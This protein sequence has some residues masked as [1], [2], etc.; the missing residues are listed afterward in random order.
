MTLFTMHLFGPVTCIEIKLQM[1]LSSYQLY[2]LEMVNILAFLYLEFKFYK[3]FNIKHPL[4]FFIQLKLI[5]FDNNVI[6]CKAF[7]AVKQMA[8]FI[9]KFH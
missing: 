2:S 1:D 9:D 3:G 8:T 7:T 6:W 5:Y 4:W